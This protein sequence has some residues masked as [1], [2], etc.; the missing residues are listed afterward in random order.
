MWFDKRLNLI[1]VSASFQRCCSRNCTI[2]P[3]SVDYSDL[4]WLSWC[5]KITGK[6]LFQQFLQRKILRL[7]FTDLCVGNPPAIGGFPHKMRVTRKIFPM[8]TSSWNKQS[9]E[10]WCI[11]HM[12]P[13]VHVIAMKSR[14]IKIKTGVPVCLIKYAVITS[15][16]WITIS[17]SI[18]R[19]KYG[20]QISRID[21]LWRLMARICV[22]GLLNPA[23]ENYLCPSLRPD[24]TRN[25]AEL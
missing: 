18:I 17:L 7:H 9:S 13:S 25:N 8:I 22:R 12:V 15:V 20:I 16:F 2:V 5:L 3:F 6:S 11:G 23:S 21:I 10:I 24:T 4:K 1:Y 14:Q 19:F